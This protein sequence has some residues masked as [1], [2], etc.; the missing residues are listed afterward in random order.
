[1]AAA[2]RLVIVRATIALT[3]V[4]N[5]FITHLS[6]DYQESPGDRHHSGQKAEQRW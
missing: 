4:V 5:L 2:G 1:M 3:T 6:Y